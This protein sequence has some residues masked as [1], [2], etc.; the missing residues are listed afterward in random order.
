MVSEN[1]EASKSYTSE[2]IKVLG[3]L[4]GVRQNFDILE[5]SKKV[6]RGGL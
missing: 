5:L 6:K 3:G 2:K 4:E 1:K